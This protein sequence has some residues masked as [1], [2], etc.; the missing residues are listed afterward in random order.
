VLVNEPLQMPVAWITGAAGGLGRALVTAFLEGGFRVAAGVHRHNP[1]TPGETLCPLTVDVTSGGA[2]ADAARGILDRWGRVDV[3]VNNA[4]ITRDSLLAGMSAED[5]TGVMDV[6]LRGAFLCSQA[7][8][9]AMS[10]QRSGHIINIS[11]FAARR[12]RAGQSNYVASKAGLIGL[13]QSLARELGPDNI[14]VNAILPGVLPT[15]MVRGLSPEKLAALAAGNTLG[16]LNDC[17]EV[18]Q[19]IRVLATLQNVSGQV[20]QLDSRIARWT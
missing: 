16:R 4:G 18:A 13:T 12:G 5:W 15:G 11:S 1:F 9:P 6:N 7:V 14:R 20:F 19:F 10:R 8:A 17:A 3:L 2:A